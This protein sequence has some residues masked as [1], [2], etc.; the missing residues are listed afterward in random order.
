MWAQPVPNQTLGM[1]ENYVPPQ[2]KIVNVNATRAI[3]H[4]ERMSENVLMTYQVIYLLL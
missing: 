2:Q 4:F 3:R 1:L